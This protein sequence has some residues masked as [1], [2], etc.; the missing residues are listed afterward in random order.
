M[1]NFCI[2]ITGLPGSGKST[3]AQ[4]VEQRF[5]EAEIPVVTLNLDHIRTYLTPEPRY[6]EEERELVYRALAYM[7]KLLVEAGEKDVI[8]DATGNRRS[9]RE[10]AREIIPEFAEIYVRC[11]L[12]ICRAREAVREGEDVEKDLYIKAGEG[13]LKGGLPGVSAP[14]EEPL[15]PEVLVPSDEL[16]PVE[17][18]IKI[19][20]YITSRWTKGRP[21]N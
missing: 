19:M 13:R 12:E 5:K 7:A 1:T 9:F 14:Y 10:F 17:S 4:E 11:P 8:L 15:R 16:S 2:W 3:V 20:A 21:S 6:S 18:S